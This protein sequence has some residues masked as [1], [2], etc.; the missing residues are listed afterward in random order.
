LAETIP[1]QFRKVSPHRFLTYLNWLIAAALAV[2]IGVAYWFLYRPVPQVSGSVIAPVASPV[3]IE[4]D[5]YGIP[6]ITAGSVED[7]LFAQ[8]FVMAQDRLWQMDMMRRTA[9]GA[10]A[11]VVGPAGLESD[12]EVRRLR[13]P[14]LAA[15]YARRLPPADKAAIAAFA[16]G[17]NHAIQLSRSRW[18]VEFTLLDYDPRPWSVADT[19][20][21]CLQMFRSLTSTWKAELAKESMLES[22]DPS[23]VEE[24]FPVRA[25]GELQPGSNAWAISGRRSRTGKPILANDPHLEFTLP[26]VWHLVHLKAPGLNVAGAALVGAP[27]VLIGRNERIAW[28]VTNVG[29][30]VQDLYKEQLDPRTGRY[31]FQNHEEQARAEREVILIKGAR[32]VDAAV[33]VT[34]HGPLFL[35]ENGRYLS[36][37]WVA[38]DLEDFGYPILDFNRASNWEEFRAA[39]KRFSGPAQNFVYADVDGNIGYQVAGRLPVRRKGAGDIPADGAGGAAEWEGFIP[40]ER[41]PSVFNPPSGEIVT[42]NQNPFP[43]DYPYP[44]SGNFAPPYR[45]AQIHS[46]LA[47]REKWLP[48]EMFAVQCDVYSAFSHF[49]ASQLVAAYEK[50]GKTNAGLQPV[51]ELLKHWNGQ[52]EKGKPEPLVAIL[53]FQHLRKA[54]AEKA[55]PGTGQRYEAQMAPAVLERLLKQRPKSWFEDWDQVLLRALVD[56]VDEGKRMQGR[57]PKLWD[58]GVYNQLFLPHP[59]LGRVKWFGQYFNMGPYPM[60]GSATT[61]M[62]MTRRLGPSLRFVADLSDPDRS[63]AHIVTGESGH[64]LSGHYKDQWPAY[65]A[66]RGL[67]LPLRRV[68]SKHILRLEPGNSGRGW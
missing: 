32:T 38:A 35:S 64:P 45:A 6:H 9:T 57:D 25:G 48:E 5:D 59:V 47:A 26:S 58:Y 42:A 18:P 37:R 3:V 33:W 29:F 19:L 52:M 17:V 54:V 4:R 20:A 11:E 10:L 14:Q 65:Y 61:V 1:I 12:L 41:L 62:Q 50:R 13:I 23:K 53:A 63:L 21:V 30:D 67:P 39:C 7:A 2:C 60:S 15:Q 51:V 28:G 56:A 66:A 8:G 46:R 44:V 49:L 43:E 36:L 31:L 55:A 16:R 24:L 27:G 22:G 40:F 68:A 34:R